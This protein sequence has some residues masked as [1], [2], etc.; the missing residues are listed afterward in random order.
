MQRISHHI[1]TSL[2]SDGYRDSRRL[3]ALFKMKCYLRLP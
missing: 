2:S 3:S 1:V